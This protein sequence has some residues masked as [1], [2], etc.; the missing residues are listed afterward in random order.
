[1]RETI[2]TQKASVFSKALLAAGLLVLAGCGDSANLVSAP[3]KTGSAQSPSSSKVEVAQVNA[4]SLL[5]KAEIDSLTGRASLEPREER[6]AEL[7]TCSFGDPQ[8]PKIGD[9][10]VTNVVELGVFSGGSG[11]YAGPLQQAQDGYE[12]IQKNA[13]DVATVQ[14]VGEKAYWTGNILRALRGA[15]FIE[16]EVDGNSRETAEKIAAQMLAKMP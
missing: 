13:G 8:A 16:V 11:Y 4:C 1:M 12:M 7:S 10:P 2:F 5:S 9:R 3:A 15:Y 6:I 14:G